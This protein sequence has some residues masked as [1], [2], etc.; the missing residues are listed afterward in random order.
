MKKLKIIGLLFLLLILIGTTTGIAWYLYE[1]ENFFAT[2][3]AQITADMIT[4]T[5]EITGKLESW[6]IREGDIVTSG[7]VLGKQGIGMMVTN[8]A[9]NVQALANS[10]DSI[11]DRTEIKSPITGK[12]V[13]TNVIKG[14]VIAP[15]ME[16]ATIADTGYFYIKAH[17]EETDI[18]RIKPG[19]KVEISIDAYPDRSFTGSVKSIGQATESAFNTFPSLN[20]SGEYTKVTQLIPIKINIMDTEDLVFMPGMN[21]TI[22]IHLRS[23]SE[24]EKSPFYFLFR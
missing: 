19:Q 13:Q 8:T 2:E 20:T 9:I 16:I 1:S 11:I 3:D 23:E 21:A 6:D 5:P 22:R 7:Q 18:F 12:V 4:I 24:R 15:G 10:A 14:Q 17:I